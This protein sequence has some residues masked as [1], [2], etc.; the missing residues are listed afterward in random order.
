MHAELSLPAPS[1]TL[2]ELIK[3]SV[4]NAPIDP[5]AKPWLDK[6]HNNTINSPLQLGGYIVESISQQMTLEFQ[7]F[8]PKHTL[9]AFISIMKNTANTIA[10]APPHTDRGRSLA[11]NYFIELG[12]DN[13][14]TVFYNYHLPLKET[15]SNMLYSETNGIEYKVKFTHG[16]YAFNV[17]QCH[18]VENLKTTRIFVAIMLGDDEKT[19]STYDFN[20]LINDY[21]ELIKTQPVTGT[22]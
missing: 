1:S 8:F 14:E 16:W 21:P 22:R 6:F 10:S 15:A 17:T 11:I 19:A 4:V 3:Q 7:K 5:K 20:N 13:V 2:I 12:G 9:H 18:S